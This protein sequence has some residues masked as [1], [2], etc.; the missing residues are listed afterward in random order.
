MPAVTLVL[1]GVFGGVILAILLFMVN[2]RPSRGTVAPRRT[3][4]PLTTDL[5]NMA[6]IPVAG[7]GGLGLIAAGIVIALNVP[8]IGWSLA[9]GV[10]LGGALAL[11]L[12]AYRSR[13]AGIGGD[14]RPAPPAGLLV[15]DQRASAPSAATR[16][17]AP[18][19]RAI[20]IA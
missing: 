18:G 17:N 9:A 12:I 3:L 2:R 19:D 5:I 13:R 4:E 8:E 20:A 7:I 16:E 14:G 11:G 10:G 1:P 15:N 6:H